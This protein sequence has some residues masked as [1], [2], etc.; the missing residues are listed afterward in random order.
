MSVQFKDTVQNLH[1]SI[2]QASGYT[3]PYQHWLLENILP[4]FVCDSLLEWMPDEK[5]ISGDIQ[6]RRENNNQNRVFVNPEKQQQ[7]RRCAALAQAFE[8]QET[9]DLFSKVT[10]ADLSNTWLRLELCLDKE[11][12]WLEHHT[13]IGA[14]KLTFLISLSLGDDAENWGTDIMNAQ[15]DSL[16]RSSG[17][18]NSAFMFIPSKDTWHGYKKRPMK[19][20]RRTLIMNYVNQNWRAKHELAFAYD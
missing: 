15:G 5:A 3:Y 19:G 4:D 6:G 12:F 17:K 11:G 14:K 7:D 10:G 9:R 18:F 13:D 2:H 1:R 16:A 20:I 8:S